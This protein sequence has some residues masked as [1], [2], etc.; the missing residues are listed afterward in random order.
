MHKLLKR[1][2]KQCVDV[3]DL[4]AV[5]E[6]W[7]Q[8][9]EVISRAYEQSDDDRNLLERSLE[10]TSQELQHRYAKLLEEIAQRQQIE[11]A[12][13]K[14]QGQLEVR[15]QERTAEL[16]SANATLQAEV[17]ERTRAE[18]E[19]HVSY[20]QLKELLAFKEDL[21]AKVSHE[22]RT[23]LTSIKEGLNLLRDHALGSITADQQE[24]L[25]IMNQDVDRLTG[26][27]S[28]VLDV[29]TIEAGRMQ[30]RRDRTDLR[31]L[32]EICVESARPL[33]SGRRVSIEAV[34]SAVAFADSD[35]LLQVFKS[36]L[37]NAIKFTA[38]GGMIAFRVD[39]QDHLVSI[40]ITDDGVGISAVDVPKLFQK[41]S[42]VGQRDP[43]QPRG[44]GL[45]LVLCKEL[46]E[47]H[48]GRIEVSSQLG[49]GTTFTV[50][51]PAYTTALALAESFQELRA[52]AAKEQ[53]RS[54]GLVVVDLEDQTQ[55]QHAA[56][57]E[58]FR[59]LQRVAQDVRRLVRSEDTVLAIE[60][61]LIV[62]LVIG[63]ADGLQATV[64]RLRQ[65]LPQGERLRCGTALYP[66]NGASAAEL[67]TYATHVMTPGAV[68]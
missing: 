66:A 30:L 67:F 29:S 39:S 46:V 2:L 23:P 34:E 10:L 50:T 64:H 37:S 8:L 55:P 16:A 42:Q 32:L 15:V 13:R 41:F 68:Q 56:K 6:S 4:G 14:V 48:K 28:N 52:V 11:E 22:L 63:K 17:T 20:K 35:R 44:T 38:P 51:L 49:K 43:N 65:L 47:L 53:E 5:S 59:Q 18:Q 31:Q 33:L 19:L 3:E 1:Q 26:L 58:R 45:G 9:L 40:E 60:P 12:L 57:E 62:V 27:V 7:R 36:L 21:V 25:T 24:F 54:V 61:S